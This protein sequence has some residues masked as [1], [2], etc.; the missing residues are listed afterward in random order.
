MQTNFL[1]SAA[2]IIASAATLVGGT[3]SAATPGHMALQGRMPHA[4]HVWEKPT[5]LGLVTAINGN[6]LTIT[7]KD[8]TVYTIDASKATIKGFTKDKKTITLADLKVGDQI[9]VT[10]TLSG[11]AISAT[12]IIDGFGGRMGHDNE[13]KQGHMPGLFGTVATTNGGVFTVT[14]VNRFNS[15]TPNRTFTV[16]TSATTTYTKDGQAATLTDLATGERVMIQGMVDT[17]SLTVAATK[18]N[19]VTKKPALPETMK[20]MIHKADHMM[21]GRPTEKHHRPNKAK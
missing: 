6:S 2:G 21:S 16:N 15:T 11:T 10:G 17:S 20:R 9:A 5:A 3:V 7:T 1:L 13:D 12:S 4:G 8:G 18:V 14:M 19:I